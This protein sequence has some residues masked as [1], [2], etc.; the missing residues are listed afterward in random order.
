VSAPQLAGGVDHEH[1]AE[2][3]DEELRAVH[4]AA[5]PRRADQLGW[6]R[7]IAGTSCR[8]KKS[9]FSRADPGWARSSANASGRFAGVGAAS[10]APWR[11]AVG[12]LTLRRPSALGP[13]GSPRRGVGPAWAG[14]A[15]ARPY[16]P[17]R[18]SGAAAQCPPVRVPAT[19]PR[20]PVRGS[21]AV[22]AAAVR[23]PASRASL[24]PRVL[25]RADGRGSCPEGWSMRAGMP[26]PRVWS[27][28]APAA[29]APCRGGPPPATEDPTRRCYDASG[30]RVGG[31]P[32]LRPKCFWA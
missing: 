18:G 31:F 13:P 22:E 16:G 21:A 2:L 3:P 32:G 10:P 4:A 27:T 1:L 23:Q 19:T 14:G 17:R 30:E 6:C 5:A 28:P 15:S 20:P 12:A 9:A 8:S 25:R 26:I 29:T 7:R 11:G 24:S